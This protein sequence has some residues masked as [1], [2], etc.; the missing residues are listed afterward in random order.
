[1][2]PSASEASRTS[3]KI[4]GIR[5]SFDGQ[6]VLDNLNFKVRHREFLALL[7]ESGC[8]KTTLLRLIAGFEKPERGEVVVKGEVFSTPKKIVPPEKRKI[9]MVFQDYALFPHL[10]VAENIMFGMEGKT[11]GKRKRLEELLEL[12]DLK[13]HEH[14][15]PETISGGQQQ[16]TAVARALAPNPSIILMDE[17]FS[18]LDHRLRVKLREEIRD[19]LSDFGVTVLL[20]THDQEEAF[21]FCDRVLMMKG[22]RIVQEGT[23]QQI[24]NFPL[25][26]WVAS[27]VGDSNFFNCNGDLEVLRSM[28][29][30]GN[31]PDA[32]CLH[33]YDLVIRP[34]DLYLSETGPDKANGLVLKIEF[35]GNVQYALVKLGN[36]KRIKVKI[37][38]DV[39]LSPTQ[40]IKVIC[41]RY[42]IFSEALLN[43]GIS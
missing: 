24:Y 42:H 2:I 32:A 26:K 38:K 21:A 20:V 6:T 27:F 33:E 14:K 3:I 10:T 23:P 31:L 40:P 13:G 41:H 35:L 28:V 5:K 15:M 9:G 29:L 17:P 19:I 22:G 30:S 34:E 4:Q 7:G 12:M 43:G 1:M 16:R 25:N 8:G 36:D 18:N 11:A 39:E 37:P